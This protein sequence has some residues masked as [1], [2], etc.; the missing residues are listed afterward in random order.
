[1]PSAEARHTAP[2]YLTQ[3]RLD[4]DVYTLACERTANTFSN[5]DHCAVMFSGGKDSTAV[6]NVA[7][8]VAHSDPRFERHLPL[9]VIFF[10][11]EAIPYETVN[12]VR[13]MF[14]RDDVAGEWMCLPL[15]HRNACS[16]RSPWWWTWAP[17]AREKWCRP[18]PPEAITELAGF[19]AWP[20]A[21]R[22]TNPD[23]MGL[24]FPPRL[25]NCAQLMGI[26]AQ[27]SLIRHRAVTRRRVDNYLNKF[28]EGTSCGNIWKS[29]PVYDWTTEDVWTAPNV[30]GWDYNCNVYEAPLWMADYSFKP[31]GEAK[32]GDEIIGFAPVVGARAKQGKPR[33]QLVRSTVLSV[34]KRHSAVV[35]VTM[36]SGRTI[37]CTPDHMWMHH[38]CGHPDAS[39]PFAPPKVGH[40]LSH[41]VDVPSEL[42]A[43]AADFRTAAWL[44]GVY[45]GEGCGDRIYQNPDH[46]P[47][48]YAAIEEALNK[49]GVPHVRLNGRSK[50]QHG[51]RI[52]G[53][54]AGLVRF[55]N[56]VDPVR[57]ASKQTD[58][59][60]LG[61]RFRVADK[62]VSIEPD[63][64]GDVY[65]LTT[66][67]GNYVCW[68]YASKNS[69][70]DRMEMAGVPA[71]VQ[72][73][74]PAFGEEPLQKIH[75]YASCFPDV[76]AKMV[77][78]VPGVGAAGRY[79]LTELYAYRDRPEKPA[80]VPWGE[81]L[82][83]YV[84]KFQPVDA[85]FIAARMQ[86]E[87]QLHYRHCTDPIS[88][89]APHP[90]TGLSW[91]FLLTLAMRGDFKGRK[92]AGARVHHDDQHRPEPKYWRRYARELAGIIDAG[93]FGELSHPGPQPAD[94]FEMIP[95]YAREETPA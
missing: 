86:K 90:L 24:F 25:G 27:E 47:A 10:D 61:G 14:S 44:A 40:N 7:L 87:I 3:R 91:D 17:E 6:L 16:R 13:R 41:V 58:Q 93:R 59:A 56:L 74:S 72:R 8:E 18:L 38:R 54:R 21:A 65:A 12:Y 49:L 82:L 68:G 63:G 84:R 33:E 89:T 94:P 81:F 88:D 78:R 35:K 80:G 73:C 32:A 29:Y 22:L 55:L 71:A 95:A 34:H 23:A 75:T 45:D 20:P 30:F 77:D 69:A 19:P 92:Q 42:A 11:E 39:N 26:R 67:T 62:I 28:D 15:K 79:A 5:F 76:W 1:M 31:I 64:E 83:H 85:Q 52:T 53:G 4:Q 36:E 43:A 57:R 46:N 2:S 70:Y 60:I 51:F 48:V 66:T 50:A 37:R 9:R